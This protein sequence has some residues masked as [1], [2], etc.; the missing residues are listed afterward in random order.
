M[1]YYIKGFIIQ[2]LLA[3]MIALAGIL[4]ITTV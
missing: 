2:L 4:R 1:N 3:L